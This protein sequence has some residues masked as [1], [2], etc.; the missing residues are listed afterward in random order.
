MA[1][2]L[3][4]FDFLS[5]QQ[6]NG[7]V[8]QSG[9]REMGKYFTRDSDTGLYKPKDG[10]AWRSGDSSES[11]ARFTND[12]DD[13]WDSFDAKRD[14]S[15]YY[16]YQTGPTGSAADEPP[17]PNRATGE[18]DDI[19]G[20]LR[21]DQQAAEDQ[22]T[23]YAEKQAK[24]YKTQTNQLTRSFKNQISQLNKANAANIDS[25]NSRYDQQTAQFNEFQTLAADQLATAEANYQEQQ[26]MVG[27]LQSAFVPEANPSAFTAAIGDQRS[28][29]SR[30]KT[31]NRLSDLSSLSIVSGLGTASN[32][33]S[34][35]QLA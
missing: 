34:G 26:R 22:A 6:F 30:P 10:Y 4:Y 9:E 18:Y 2:D 1:S 31:S 25:L 15:S 12:F 21:L 32:P 29:G 8:G 14:V 20:S 35:L 28:D 13:N 5:G 7:E 19:I 23:K 33:L 11:V 24:Q 17:V 27:N 16:V 3:F